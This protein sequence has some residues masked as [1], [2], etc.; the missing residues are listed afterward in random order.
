MRPVIRSGDQRL[1]DR[2]TPK[3]TWASDINETDII[4]SDMTVMTIYRVVFNEP[5][6]KGDDRV[7]FYFTSLSA[8]YDIFSDAQIGC[9]VTRLWNIGVSNG[10]PYNGKLCLITKE[11]LT[12][13]AQMN[14]SA[15][16]NKQ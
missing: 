2:R 3:I 6:I 10:T 11:P 14:P 8:I 5:P 9:K 7:E 12:T 4:E 13:K 16:R 15:G 1:T